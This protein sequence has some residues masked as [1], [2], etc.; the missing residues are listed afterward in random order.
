MDKLPK[1]KKS[2]LLVVFFSMG[3]PAFSNAAVTC[4]N[5]NTAVSETTPT[6]DFVDNSD[7]T[8]THSKTGLV[9]MQCSLG[10]GWDGTT[11]TGS[12]AL[13]TWQEAL[14]AAQDINSGISN[15]DGDSLAGF[16]GQTDWRLPNKNELESIVERRCWSP[17]A[18]AALFP[19]TPSAWF[20][21]SSPGANSPYDAWGIDFGVGNVNT[22]LKVNAFRV[23][24]VRAGQ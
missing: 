6:T 11:C 7:G 20:W 9:W 24:L 16:A 13:Y 15:A 2:L 17:A 14:Q 21:S 19:S 8:V 1:K 3:Y 4:V 23:R 5:D 18:N 10:Q 12:A 22:Y